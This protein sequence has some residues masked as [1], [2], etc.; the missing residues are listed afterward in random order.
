MKINIKTI[1][2]GVL[3]K[4]GD[5]TKKSFNPDRDW[6]VVLL[7]F[8]FLNIIIVSLFIV[9]LVGENKGIQFSA[10]EN[11]GS[12]ETINRGKMQDVVDLY[13]QKEATFDALYSNRV[14]YLDPE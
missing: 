13:K 7:V 6:K 2:D 3:G 10:S 1:I 4:Q 11:A 12:T 8:F 9:L 14:E 5:T